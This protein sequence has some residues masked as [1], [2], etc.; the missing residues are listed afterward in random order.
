MRP[1]DQSSAASDE[2]CRDRRLALLALWLVNG[3]KTETGQNRRR[4]QPIDAEHAETPAQC[5]PLSAADVLKIAYASQPPAA[6]ANAARP[7]LQFEIVAARQ[8]AAGFSPVRDGDSLRSEVDDYGI[9]ARALSSGW[10]YV[11]QVD[12][13]G[14]KEWLFPQNTVVRKFVGLRIR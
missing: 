14:N 3:P 4:R 2:C 8:G 7:Q 6:P 11:F 1:A 9:V 13:S 5:G 12:S 10:L